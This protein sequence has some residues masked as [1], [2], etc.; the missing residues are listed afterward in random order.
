MNFEQ[1]TYIKEV[2]RTGS[3]SEAAKNCYVSIPAISQAISSLEKELDV[4]IFERTRLGSFP[5]EEGLKIIDKTYE[6]TSKLDELREIP[7]SKNQIYQG[8]LNI[9][10]SPSMIISVFKTA[11][12]FKEEYPNVDI[13]I[14][15]N[16]AGEI[17]DT[18]KLNINDIGFLFI[19]ENLLEELENWEFETLIND[20]MFLCVGRNS[21]LAEKKSINPHDLL[22]QRL[23][24][25]SGV[26]S[27]IIVNRFLENNSKVNILFESNQFEII[28]KTISEG[29]AVSFLNGLLLKN[30]PRVISGEI[31]P[32]P[33]SN[34]ENMDISYGWLR[35]K[36]TYFSPITKKFL[37]YFKAQ[38]KSE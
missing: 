4:R 15:E 28:K 33:L 17:I 1:L 6:I 3:I 21:P 10:A 30:E 24:T 19:N 14:T 34:F 29:F 35:M 16:M 8:S 23:V 37:S 38:I 11:F 18:L 36:N 20:K 31:V 22:D 12:A 25:Y 2:Y 7:K 9:S 27:K 13:K 5:T 26:N 32:L